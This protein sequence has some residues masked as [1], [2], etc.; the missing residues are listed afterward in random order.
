M[1][2]ACQNDVRTVGRKALPSNIAK[3]LRVFVYPRPEFDDL[4][5]NCKEIASSE[6]RSSHGGVEL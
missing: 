1:F 5:A 2:I 4:V 6:L 3:R